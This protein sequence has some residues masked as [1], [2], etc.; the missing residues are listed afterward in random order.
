[1]IL[2]LN[3]NYLILLVIITILNKLYIWSFKKYLLDTIA[4]FINSSK[5]IIFTW[6]FSDNFIIQNSN[7]FSYNQFFFFEKL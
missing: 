5:K 6:I 7:L 3:Y 2:S 4:N 1:M